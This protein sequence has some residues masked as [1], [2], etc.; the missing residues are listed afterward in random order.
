MTT[1]TS[2]EPSRPATLIETR[3]A[4]GATPRY[5]PSE[6]QPAPAR[7]PP[8]D[9]PELAGHAAAQ[10][11]H[12]VLRGRGGRPGLPDDHG[13]DPRGVGLRPGDEDRVSLDRN[14]GRARRG[15]LHEDGRDQDGD[16]R[17]DQTP[18]SDPA[19]N[20]PALEP[21]RGGLGPH[22]RRLLRQADA[23]VRRQDSYRIGFGPGTC[24]AGIILG[25][26]RRIIDGPFALV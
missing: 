4:A 11:P 10:G 5:V 13:E 2:V 3:L 22:R 20:D 18:P 21:D 26:R 16:S 24:S 8:T 14:R 9:D 12:E 19:E 1:E 25:I 23:D 6:G 15:R 7:T 17:P